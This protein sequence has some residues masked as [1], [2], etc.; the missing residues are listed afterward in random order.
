M[1]PLLILKGGGNISWD[2]GYLQ[3]GVDGI[4]SSFDAILENEARSLAYIVYTCRSV[5]EI[6]YII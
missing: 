5:I 1:A 6:T 4:Q 3:S 2:T